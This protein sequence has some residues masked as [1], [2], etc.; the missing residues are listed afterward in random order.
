MRK[1]SLSIIATASLIASSIIVPTA[2]AQ[3]LEGQENVET[4]GLEY[5]TLIMGDGEIQTI[6]IDESLE[7]AKFLQIEGIISEISEEMNGNFLVTVGGEQPF[8]FYFDDKTIILDNLGQKV[9]L[10]EGMKFTAYV[11]SNKPMIMIYP[12]RYSPEVVIV[13]TEEAGT[14]QQDQFDENFLNKNKDLVLNLNDETPIYNLS[15]KKLSKTDIIN[16]NV[17]VFYTVSTKSLPAQTSPSKI[18]V[19]D[20]SNEELAYK[21]AEFDNYEVNGV[22]M[23]PLRLIAE[24][25][26]YEVEYTGKGAILSKGPVS[27]TITI[28]EKM[29]GYNKALRNFSEAP[30]L[31]EYGKTYVPFELLEML[32]G[33][34]K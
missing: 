21:I 15:G 5:K 12:P 8:N 25:L 28:G 6:S 31:L 17:L 18:I 20:P 33:E 23:I 11:D 4:D 10:K 22:K 32:V 2:S 27:Y 7:I 29:Y 24:Q 9:E 16:K 3:Y 13:K 34:T 19:L 26:G 1:K 30:A 14:V